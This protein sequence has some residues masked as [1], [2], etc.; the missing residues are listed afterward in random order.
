MSNSPVFTSKIIEWDDQKGFGYLLNQKGK[1]F[2]HR[3]DF[4]ERHKRPVKGDRV[5]YQIGTDPKG[6]RCAVEARHVNDGGKI[7][8]LTWISLILFPAMPIF[9]WSHLMIINKLPILF[10]ILPL[11]GINIF[12]YSTYKNDKANARAK[13]WRTSEA[14]L[15]FLELIGGWPAAFVAQ[16]QFRHKCSKGSFQ[17]SYWAIVIIH[18]SL[19]IDYIFNLG[20][21]K[22]LLAAIIE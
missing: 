21:T 12:T 2:L 10:L 5:H 8:I 3:K 18:V 1:L 4:A 13:A 6:R 7:T 19:A 9:A 16:R 20:L 22:A 11:L 14:S 15:H 17:V